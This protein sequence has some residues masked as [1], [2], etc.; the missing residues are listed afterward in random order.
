MFC[1]SYT[2]MYLIMEKV[3]KT[4]E[5]IQNGMYKMCLY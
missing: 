5:N 1:N 2:Y 3:Q 4:S